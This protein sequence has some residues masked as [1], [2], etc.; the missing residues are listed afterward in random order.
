MRPLLGVSISPMVGSIYNMGVWDKVVAALV[1]AEVRR[2]LEGHAVSRRHYQATG[3][4]LENGGCVGDLHVV[5]ERCLVYLCILYCCMAMGRLQVAFIE[6]RLGDLPKDHAVGVQLVLYRARTGVRLGAS[7]SPDGEKAR[8]LFLTWEELGPL[9]AYALEDDESQAGVAMRDLLL[10]LYSDTGAVVPSVVEALQEGSGRDQPLFAGA[11]HPHMTLES[12]F[13]RLMRCQIR[14]HSEN[15]GTR[16]RGSKRRGEWT[17]HPLPGEPLS[18]LPEGISVGRC[19]R[20]SCA[21]LREVCSSGPHSGPPALGRPGM[22]PLVAVG[23]A[24]PLFGLV[25]CSRGPPA[26]RI[27]PRRAAAVRGVGGRQA[28]HRHRV[29]QGAHPCRSRPRR[30]R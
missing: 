17:W 15:K 5:A 6:A 21:A 29:R 26:L 27:Q 30:A 13:R 7:V 22:V 24:V 14:W 16:R 1:K 19:A 10:Y 8:A 11:S 25:D 23:E 28:E 20:S 2:T 18:P 4:S 12:V 9:L 3:L